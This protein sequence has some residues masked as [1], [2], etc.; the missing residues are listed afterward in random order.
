M[1]QKT[2]YDV[3]YNSPISENQSQHHA[4]FQD[5]TVAMITVPWQQ[6]AGNM[7]TAMNTI[8]NSAHLM[9][10]LDPATATLGDMV[11]AWEAFR[12]QLQELV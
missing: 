11:A 4:A 9:T 6:W 1:T 10:D 7:G 3:P 2:N 12:A 5:E 8:V